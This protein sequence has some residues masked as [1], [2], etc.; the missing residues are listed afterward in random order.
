[1]RGCP[2]APSQ[3]RGLYR[4]RAGHGRSGKVRK[5][6]GRSGKVKK[7]QGYGRSRKVRKSQDMSGHG[8]AVSQCQGRLGVA[9]HG[10]IMNLDQGI[11]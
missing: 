8:M 2:A 5:G 4:V 10:R 7:G 1:M 11:I 6:Q 9:G 3:D